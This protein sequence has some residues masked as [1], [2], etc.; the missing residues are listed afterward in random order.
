MT[1]THVVI[2]KA[3]SLGVK[4]AAKMFYTHCADS[5]HF[6]G[7]IHIINVKHLQFKHLLWAEL[8]LWQVRNI[9]EMA[10]CSYKTHCL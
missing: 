3:P 7:L 1:I 2:F 5:F 8:P 4:S 6:K 10:K 9:F